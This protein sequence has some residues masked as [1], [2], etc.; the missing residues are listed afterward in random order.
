MRRDER[1]LGSGVD[2]RC[3]SRLHRGSQR[4]FLDEVPII[5]QQYTRDY[6]PARHWIE[7]G[8][9]ERRESIVGA[10]YS[11]VRIGGR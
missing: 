1:L 2:L 10:V 4:V 6:R 5:L 8:V 7:F 9:E 11:H 3:E